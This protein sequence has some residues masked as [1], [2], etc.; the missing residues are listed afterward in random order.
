[1]ANTRREEVNAP[2]FEPKGGRVVPG[3]FATGGAGGVSVGAAGDRNDGAA[4]VFRQ[5]SAGLKDLSGAIGRWADEAAAEE[6]R[7]EGAL[8]G[9]DPEFRPRNEHTIFAKNYD[10][11]AVHTW[12]GQMHVQVTDQLDKAFI[13]HQDNP[14]ALAKA[15][16]ALKQGWLEKIDPELAPH[17]LPDFERSFNAQNLALSRQATRNQIARAREQQLATLQTEIA[18]RLKTLDQQSFRLGLDD[19][20]DAVLTQEITALHG[21]LTQR[22]AD[23]RFVLDPQMQERIRREVGEQVSRSR[24]IGAFSRIDG[25]DARAQFIEKLQAD[26]KAGG[27]KLLDQ[28]DVPAYERLVGHLSA[29]ANRQT[30]AQQLATR[31]LQRELTAMQQAADDGIEFGPERTRAL[32]GQ[33][34]IA[35]KPEHFQ[36]VQ[37]AQ[38]TFETVRSLNA[39]PPEKVEAWALSER[40]RLREAGTNAGEWELERLRLAER[41][42]ASQKAQLVNGQIAVAAKAGIISGAALDMSAGD[43]FTASLVRRIPEADHAA[44]FYRREVQYFTAEERTELGVIARKGGSEMLALAQGIVAAAGER[45]PEVLRELDKTA[46]PLAIAGRL[47][48]ENAD[49][50][51]PTD[52]AK[53]LKLQRTE[54]FSERLKGKDKDVRAALTDVLGDLLQRSPELEANVGPAA[55]AMY[56]A[57]AARAGSNDFDA[58]MMKE[59]VRQAVGERQ[60]DGATYGGVVQQSGWI[61]GSNA[62]VLPTAVKQRT[63]RQV[64]EMITPADLEAAGLGVPIGGDGKS[65]ALSRVKAATLVQYGDGRYVIATGDPATPGAEGWVFRD[66]PGTPYVLDLKTLAPILAR[67]RPDLFLPVRP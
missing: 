34:A 14:A 23:G 32:Q 49:P 15:T 1:M 33:L 6:G 9:F 12:K 11:A 66:R 60:V 59:A 42:I 7:Q 65:V 18:T 63:W 31:T 4:D 10:H 36:A 8:A 21:R 61:W 45:A 3:S 22:G 39:T 17:V 47:I 35:G 57:R 38:A 56:E 52:L 48:L 37:R 25:Q 29:E 30:L 43:K 64:V 53:G 26:Y 5:A 62:I 16:A 19:T 40:Q 51:A 58:S 41:Y 44:A 50:N 55:R 46:P 13:Q 24:I 27:N 28:F 20:A 54:G 67:R 2:A